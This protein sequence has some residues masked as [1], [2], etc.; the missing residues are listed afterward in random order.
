[1]LLTP[2]LNLWLER[3]DQVVLSIWRVRLLEAIAQTGSISRAAEQ[4]SVQYRLAWNRLEEMESGL[5]V[6]L[7]V[8]QVG[9]AGGGET[10]LT[11]AGE[12]YVERFNQ[13]VAGVEEVVAEQFGAA[14][15]DCGQ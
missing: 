5:G 13:F 11:E 9:G 2:H 1:M 8:R 12:V 3:D 14:F 7:V 15:A 6:K 4:L 10:H